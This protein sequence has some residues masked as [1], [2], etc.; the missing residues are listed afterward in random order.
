MACLPSLSQRLP[1][2]HKS[3]KFTKLLICNFLSLMF[4]DTKMI[5]ECSKICENTKAVQTLRKKKYGSIDFTLTYT[6]CGKE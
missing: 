2:S 5:G 3:F 6:K 4:F 1:V